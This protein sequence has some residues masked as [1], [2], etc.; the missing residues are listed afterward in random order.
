MYQVQK[1]DGNLEEFNRSKIVNSIIKSGANPEEA[2][3]ITAAIEVWLPTVAAQTPVNTLDIRAK[4]LES[5][6]A[7]NPAAATNFEAYRKVEAPVAQ[8]AEPIAP[9]M[10]ATE[11]VSA[12]PQMPTE[13]APSVPQTPVEAPVEETQVDT[14]AQPEQPIASSETNQNPDENQSSLS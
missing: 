6:R 4:I 3:K 10:P 1:K 8:P 2:E 9:S 13:P 7:I 11:P 5:L 14:T 12:A